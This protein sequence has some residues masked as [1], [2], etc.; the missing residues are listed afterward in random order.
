MLST[1]STELSLILAN[2]QINHEDIR[3]GEPLVYSG[4]DSST[5]AVTVTRHVTFR[6]DPVTSTGS[7]HSHH[8]L[9]S[10]SLQSLSL[11][12]PPPPSE[13]STDS[14]DFNLIGSGS[15]SDVVQPV[16]TKAKNKAKNT[17]AIPSPRARRNI[18][19]T[20]DVGPAGNKHRGKALDVW[21]FFVCED[22]ENICVFCKYVILYYLT[23]V[24]M[25][26]RR[27]REL[28]AAN[29]RHRIAHFSIRTATGPLRKHLLSC[30]ENNWVAVC[31][32]MG[33]TIKSAA[34]QGLT[35]E[36]GE[37]FGYPHRPFSNQNFVDAIIEFVIG[38][39]L[40]SSSLF[41]GSY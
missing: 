19:N 4:P 34:A 22:E 9:P 27:L 10:N 26:I 7:T 5:R 29:G 14:E 35:D 36:N 12:T 15:D 33:I 39:D 21:S 38:D 25:L 32:K 6:S 37:G 28:H 24:F 11:V 18:K 8:S 31:K 2:A 40:V 17:R 20:K 1:E 13:F 23:C 3:D 16:R 41:Y 30:H